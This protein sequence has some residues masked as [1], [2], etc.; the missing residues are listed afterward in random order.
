MAFHILG[1][2]SCQASSC[3]ELAGKTQ[4]VLTS[5]CNVKGN[6][7]ACMQLV[8]GGKCQPDL[9]AACS[10]GI[11]CFPYMSACAKHACQQH[12]QVSCRDKGVHSNLMSMHGS[13]NQN[14]LLDPIGIWDVIS[15]R[16]T[17]PGSM[18]AN[19]AQRPAEQP[20][21]QLWTSDLHQ[22]C[23]SHTQGVYCMPI[24]WI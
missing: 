10:H 8:L 14:G 1:L 21:S 18:P 12:W 9:A 17:V 5:A 15:Y 7:N 23:P 24:L 2:F 13:F 16:H 20:A 19:E 22:S 3:C 11:A 4:N 6:R